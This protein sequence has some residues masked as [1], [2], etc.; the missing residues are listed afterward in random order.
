MAA[1]ILIVNMQYCVHPHSHMQIS[2][3]HCLIIA[4]GMLRIGT[5]LLFVCSVDF[6]FKLLVTCV[7][8]MS[9]KANKLAVLSFTNHNIA[10][11]YVSFLFS[12]NSRSARP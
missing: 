1:S 2:T 6:L 4:I 11:T 10:S 5:I 9:Y 12:S 8:H 7:C 3:L